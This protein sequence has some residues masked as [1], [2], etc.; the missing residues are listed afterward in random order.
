M[1]F[2]RL[3]D[4][5]EYAVGKEQEAMDFYTDLAARVKSD[6]VAAELREMASMEQG[7]RDWLKENSVSLVSGSPSAPVANLKIAEYIVEPVPT[8]NMTWEDIVNLAMHRETA[9]MEMYK[10]LINLVTDDNARLMFEKLA[11]EESRHKLYFETIW[12]EQVLMD[13]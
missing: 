1:Q 6:A 11:T 9:A 13:N 4:I 12:D 2:N 5:L 10:S 8:P 7:H 3:E